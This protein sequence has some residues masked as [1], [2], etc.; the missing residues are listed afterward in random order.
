MARDYRKTSPPRAST[1]SAAEDLI[2]T[3]R[4]MSL[5]GYGILAANVGAF[6]IRWFTGNW[7]ID[8]AGHQ[9][10]NDFE[11]L[12][13]GGKL[14]LMR[15]AASAYNYPLYA[16][17]QASA[18]NG[19]PPATFFHWVYPPTVLLLFAP[20]AL[21]PYTA[22]FFTWIAA[23]LSIYIV[24]LYEILPDSLL[25]VI[26]LLPPPVPKNLFIGQLAFLMAG[27]LAL[28]MV[29]MSRRPF[30]SGILMGFLTCKPQY[31]LFL[32]LALLL[33]RQ[34][35]VIAGAI[36]S[37]SILFL[38]TAWAFGP[39]AWI[40]FLRASKELDFVNSLPPPFSVVYLNQ[41]VLGLMHQTGAGMTAGWV[42]HLAVALLMTALV[43]QIWMRQAPQ[44]LKAAAFSI[45]VLIATPHMLAYD[46]TLLSVPAAFL[47]EDGLARGFLPRDRLVLMIC[48]L[49][50][51]LCFNFIVGPII[52]LALMGL[53]LRRVRY[54]TK[55]S[56]ATPASTS[57]S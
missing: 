54:A 41:T 34:W 12:W 16:V 20:I 25:I 51:F 39:N 42:V 35:R 15:D 10:L 29:F 23:S 21:L 38:G 6:A 33:T 46:L 30:L 27:L 36:V 4:R 48:F 13:V 32:P 55:T 18:L 47:V 9:K 56:A 22:A 37:G 7:I 5:W 26:A 49:G 17:A 1:I 52:L 24:G 2:F 44:S 8:Q 11:S 28:S 19:P 31:V 45:G 40:L 53:V 43:G 50:L 3:R 14:G 57:I